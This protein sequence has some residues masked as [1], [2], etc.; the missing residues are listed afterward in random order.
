MFF[1]MNGRR[2]IPNLIQVLQQQPERQVSTRMAARLVE[3]M[4]TRIA[5]PVVVHE[6]N[7]VGEICNNKKED[8]IIYKIGYDDVEECIPLPVL[9][10]PVIETLSNPA[11]AE[12]NAKAL[13]EAHAK[14]HAKALA[15]ALVEANAEQEVVHIDEKAEA[16]A[17][18]PA[19][20]RVEDTKK[21][22][23]KRNAR[24]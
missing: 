22:N 3:P 6:S 16:L 13:A 2:R 4:I 1:S 8:V 11:N 19:K 15:E 10:E 9:E 7:E 23:K 17:E 18:A 24:K 14:A 5:A 21:K 20:I 12:A